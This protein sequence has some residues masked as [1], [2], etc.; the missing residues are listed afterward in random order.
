M[1]KITKH[2]IYTTD[3]PELEAAIQDLKKDKTRSVN[4]TLCQ[5]LLEKLVWDRRKT[6]K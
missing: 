4:G 3:F 1:A 6:R 5:S 2:T